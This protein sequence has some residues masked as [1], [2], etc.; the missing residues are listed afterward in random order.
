V[1]KGQIRGVV[2]SDIQ[3]SVAVATLPKATNTALKHDAVGVIGVSAPN[4]FYVT[5][6]KDPALDKKFTA[7]GTVMAGSGVLQEIKTGDA[8]QS[9]RITRVGQAARDFKTD[10]DA[11]KKLVDA[12]TK[13]K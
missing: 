2:S 11:F 9:I 4:A 7:I 3:K 6:Q 5:L 8:I 13:K 1:A 10:D 12:A